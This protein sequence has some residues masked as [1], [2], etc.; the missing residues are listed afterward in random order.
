MPP[1]P[2]SSFSAVFSSARRRV[3]RRTTV[4]ALTTVTLVLATLGVTAASSGANTFTSRH[5][6]TSAR[7][8][9]WPLPNYSLRHWKLVYTDNFD[10]RKLGS[11]WGVYG[12][13]APPSNP[14]TAYWSPQHVKVAHGMMTLVGTQDQKGGRIVTAGLG[15]WG[16]K[17]LKYGKWKMLVRVTKCSEVKYAWLLWPYSGQWPS[18]GEVDFA[19]DEGGSRAGTTGSIIYSNDGSP[20]TLK[21]NYV[22]TRNPFSDWHVVGVAWTHDRIRYTIDGKVWGVRKSA[23]VPQTPMVL[24][25]Q[26]ESLVAPNQ[27]PKNFSSCNAQIGWVAEWSHR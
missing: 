23:N 1:Q 15:L 8:A 26:T 4:L 11:E 5:I 19:E 12:P 10:G 25:L 24:A 18:G 7:N 22:T 2:P 3:T 21:Q 17:P 13:D 9:N 20:A 6:V 16:A 27:V 14:N